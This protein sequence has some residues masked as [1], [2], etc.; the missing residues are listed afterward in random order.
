MTRSATAQNNTEEQES[1]R[2]VS[3]AGR[4]RHRRSDTK[5]ECSVEE[6]AR[7]LTVDELPSLEPCLL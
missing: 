1:G 3:S 2:T 6:R 7:S 4:I 5:K